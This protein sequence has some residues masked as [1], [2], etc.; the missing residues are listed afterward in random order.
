MINEE[1]IKNFNENG[2]LVL[3]NFYNYEEDINPI[4]HDIHKIIDITISKYN[5]DIKRESFNGE[6]FFNGYLDVIKYNRSYGGDIYDAVKQLPSFIG[7][8]I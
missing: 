3:R 2:V 7:L 1:Q 6:T 5:L 4:Q 8:I